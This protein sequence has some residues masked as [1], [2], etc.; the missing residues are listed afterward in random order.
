MQTTLYQRFRT[1]TLL[2]PKGAV[3]NLDRASSASL[4]VLLKLLE[5]PPKASSF[6]MFATNAPL[7]TIQ[8]RAMTLRCNY[9][10]DEEVYQC[11]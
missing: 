5:E 9:L 7:L 11:L 8:S 3:L 2:G 6:L 4:N 1:A 10:S